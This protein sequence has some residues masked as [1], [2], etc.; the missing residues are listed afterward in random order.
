VHKSPT[1]QR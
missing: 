1:K